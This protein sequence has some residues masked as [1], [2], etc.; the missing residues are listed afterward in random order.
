MCCKI[1]TQIKGQEAT[2]LGLPSKWRF[3]F[4]DPQICNVVLFDR[5]ISPAG[6]KIISPDGK[7]YHSLQSAF[8][9]IPH[10]CVQNA[11]Q[12]VETFLKGLGSRYSSCP[13]NFLVGKDY[14]INFSNEHG[15]RVI[16]FGK[17]VACMKNE[18]SLSQE[19]SNGDSVFYI[20]QYHQ[21][22]LDAAKRIGT[23]VPPLQ[24]IKAVTAW[25]G[26]I[27]FE[28]KTLC[29]SPANSVVAKIDQATPVRETM[30]V[31]ELP[32]FNSK[33]SF[34]FLRSKLGWL[35]MCNGKRW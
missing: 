23:H 17:I 28:R 31:C 16:L 4:D 9:H 14:C 26:C 24:L 1:P 7:Q 10:S 12:L 20:L 5:I 13:D 32:C 11:I 2:D 6:L 33:I 21:D 25:G 30:S 18:N 8:T 35:L 34:F 3:T 22:T 29:R 27:G 19:V 15:S